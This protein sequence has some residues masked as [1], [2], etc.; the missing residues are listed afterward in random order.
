MLAGRQGVHDVFPDLE[1]SCLHPSRGGPRFARHDPADALQLVFG[2]VEGERRDDAAVRR[3]GRDLDTVACLVDGE[4]EVGG[5]GSGGGCMAESSARI[6]A[7]AMVR[8]ADRLEDSVGVTSASS[9]A[10]VC[11]GRSEPAQCVGGLAPCR[12]KA[13]NVAAQ[14]RGRMGIAADGGN[15]QQGACAEPPGTEPD[16]GVL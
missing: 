10:L 12:G 2:D 13:G 7:H 11:M 15:A 3:L 8:I 9:G 1:G 5:R 4:S 6:V 16:A 14:G